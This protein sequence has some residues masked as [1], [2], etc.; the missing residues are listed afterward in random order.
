MGLYLFLNMLYYGQIKRKQDN[1][2]KTIKK[3][4]KRLAFIL[5]HGTIKT[6]KKKGGKQKMD[7]FSTIVIVLSSMF[8]GYLVG[9]PDKF[10]K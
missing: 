2:N 8:I 3:F 4:L 9:K 1:K 6:I 10:F 7:T 5:D